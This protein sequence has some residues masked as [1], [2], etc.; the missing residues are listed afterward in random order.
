MWRFVTAFLIV[1]I[2]G[3]VI[4]NIVITQYR[5]EI[6]EINRSRIRNYNS[7]IQFI[8]RSSISLR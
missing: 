5:T 1:L 2:M 4:A 3:A 7:L 8:A 6:Y